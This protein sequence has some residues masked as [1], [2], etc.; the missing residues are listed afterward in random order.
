M[1]VVIEA[2]LANVILTEMFIL[3]SDLRSLATTAYRNLL[4]TQQ[5]VFKMDNRM[6]QGINCRVRLTLA[7]RNR[8]RQEF[9]AYRMA[10]NET[11]IKVG[12]STGHH[13]FECRNSRRQTVLANS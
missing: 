3:M 10:D 6:I 4:R 1:G 11:M 12:K 2:I 8:T 9:E 5:Q 7:A 13:K